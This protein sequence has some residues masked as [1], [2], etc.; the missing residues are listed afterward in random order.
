MVYEQN[1]IGTVF[2]SFFSQLFSS[3]NPFGIDLYLESLKSH[4]S[5]NMNN[6]LLVDFTGKEIQEAIFKMN[7]LGALGLEGFLACFY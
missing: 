2:S 4:V 7:P 3:S 5:E 6:I 1:Q